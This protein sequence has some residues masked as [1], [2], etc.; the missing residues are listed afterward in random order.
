MPLDSQQLLRLS[1][2]QL[3]DLFATSPAGEIPDG[4]GIGTALLCPGTF[5]GRM[6]AWVARWFWRGDLFHA[7]EGYLRSLISPFGF[8]AM[9]AN[10]YKDRSRIDQGECIVM[11]FRRSLPVPRGIRDELRLVAPGLYLGRTVV[12][13]RRTIHFAISFQRPPG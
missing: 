8:Q 9:S 6:L 12:G 4:E 2:R 5:R 11:D 1:K 10:V 3:D 7:R 13:T